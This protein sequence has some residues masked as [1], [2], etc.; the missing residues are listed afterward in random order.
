M[1]GAGLLILLFVG[2]SRNNGDRRAIDP[3][4]L[5]EIIRIR[6]IDNHAHPVR[7]VSSGA[8]DREFD[9]LPGDNMEPASDPLQLRTDDPGVLEAW[10]A[11]WNY[12]YADTSVSASGNNK[13][14]AL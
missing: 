4:I 8:P 9:A 10:R 13:S 11:L 6:A 3:T 7:F 1:L 12:P 14:C 5:S 2:C